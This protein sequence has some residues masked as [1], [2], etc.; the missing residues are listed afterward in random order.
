MST[1]SSPLRCCSCNQF[2][3]CKRAD[4][5]TCRKNGK[6]CTSC[7]PSEYHLCSNINPTNI[8]HPNHPSIWTN[9]YNDPSP[10]SSIP[11]PKAP[12]NPYRKTSTTP[13]KK[14]R[15]PYP[16]PQKKHPRNPFYS[17]SQPIPYRTSISTKSPLPSANPFINQQNSVPFKRTTNNI[18]TP[19]PIPPSNINS[20]PIQQHFNNQKNNN[21]KSRFNPY[22]RKGLSIDKPKIRNPYIKLTIP[23]PFEQPTN[24]PT[25][26]P[27]TKPSTNSTNTPKQSSSTTSHPTLQKQSSNS[28]SSF[29]PSD[30]DM[31]IDS[32]ISQLEN[33]E[34]STDFSVHNK[35]KKK[36]KLNQLPKQINVNRFPVNSTPSSSPSTSSSSTTSTSPTHHNSPTKQ[37][38]HPPTSIEFTPP[39]L[40]TYPIT[41]PPQHP[42]TIT[43][44]TNQQEHQID[45]ELL[46]LYGDTVHRN[47]GTHL[48]GD[49]NDDPKWYYLWFQLISYHHPL[50]TPP[51]SKLGRDI[52]KTLANE[53]QGVRDR[54]WNS[55]KALLF[56]IIILRK[57]HQKLNSQEIKQRLRFR[58]D[59]WQSG[60][61]IAL[62]TDTITE[63][64]QY[65][66][67]KSSTL[68]ID[69][70]LQIFN[71]LVYH[72]KLREAL[73]FLTSTHEEN[74]ILQ[75]NQ[76][77]PK[78]SKSVLEV[79]KSKHPPLRIP[80]ITNPE[81]ELDKFEYV[82]QPL[83]LHITE[84]DV[85]LM[86]PQLHGSGGPTSLDS[87]L[88]SDLLLRYGTSS[89]TLRTEMAAWT[90]WLANDSPPWAA[91]RATMSTRAV[92][93]NKFPGIRPISIGESYRR[94]W[95]RLVISQTRDQAKAACNTTELCAG[96]EDGIDGA[97]HA[98]RQSTINKSSFTTPIDTYHNTSSPNNTSPSSTSS[99]STPIPHSTSSTTP[100]S[101]TPQP[102]SSHSPLPSTTPQLT[103]TSPTQPPTPPT[104]ST[105]QPNIPPTKTTPTNPSPPT[106]PNL[107]PTINH[108][109]LRPRPPKQ[110]NSSSTCSASD[111]Q[112]KP[113]PPPSSSTPTPSPSPETPIPTH[114]SPTPS[115]RPQPSTSSSTTTS[116]SSN[117]VSPS[118]SSPSTNHQTSTTSETHQ[119]SPV[120][121]QYH[122]ISSTPINSSPK[123][124]SSNTPTPSPSPPHDF[125]NDPIDVTLLDASN[126]FNEI[127]RLRCLHTIRHL[128]PSASRFAFNCYRH[129][130]QICIRDHNSPATII[131]G[132]E[133][134]Q[135]GDPLSMILYG[136]AL[137]PLIDRIHTE[138][139]SIFFSENFL[140]PW[141]AD[142]A[143]IV[144]TV[145]NTITII[146]A[147]Q[148]LGPVYGYF[149]Q[150]EKSVH[151]CSKDQISKTKPQF[152]AANL[153]FQYVEGARYLGSYIGEANF[154]P[155]WIKPQIQTWVSAVQDLSIAATK[156][157][158]AAYAVFTHCLQNQ[159]SHLSRT[160][161]NLGPFLTPIEQSI[162][163]SF[164]PTLLHLEKIDDPLREVISHPI[165]L[166]GLNILNPTIQAG[167]SYDTS[168]LATESLVDCL[169]CHAEV[170]LTLHHHNI[171]ETRQQCHQKIHK[172]HDDLLSKYLENAS[173]EIQ[174]RLA[175]AKIGG[176]WLTV[177][178]KAINGTI[179]SAEEF[180]DNL[181]LRYGF[182]PDFLPKT[183][184]GCN[185]AFTV[186]HA[187]NCRKGGL[188]NLRH[189]EI[190]NE[191]AHLC[192]IALG[193]ESIINEPSI[194][195]G[196]SN[197][198]DNTSTPP[199]EHIHSHTLTAEA[200]A[201]GDKG[202]IGFWQRH[203]TTIFDA[204]IVNTDSPS[205]SSK[206]PQHI[207]DQ[208][209]SNKK[210]KYEDAC[211]QRRRDFTPL[212]YSVDGL[213]S[214]GTTL[215]EKRLAQLL[216]NKL[217]IPYSQAIFLVHS[218]MSIALIRCNSIL[219]RTS[220]DRSNNPHPR[221]PIIPDGAAI[222]SF[223]L[224]RE[225]FF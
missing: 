208:S 24:D 194:F 217:Q 94:L 178:P 127:S 173:P 35:Q 137:T 216:Q 161:P 136:L 174:H 90:E 122:P 196:K 19:N 61:Y 185:K 115:L 16:Q 224:I 38:S 17:P 166:A 85:K 121:S 138:H 4:F 53:F 111:K 140:D 193:T 93:F 89:T 203:R 118:S 171:S 158:Q 26:P 28:N 71:Q 25:T 168:L 147:I 150:P 86:A 205:Y 10:Q 40:P 220:R 190:A 124:S 169:L 82:P 218:R 163:N 133:G 212:I 70:K 99:S 101:S 51:Q 59:Q 112:T 32:V 177:I 198:P 41:N 113:Q 139:S 192:A 49:I 141:Y 180:R 81:F 23:D 184:D 67:T 151:I 7:H 8:H 209:E 211:H 201:R 126:G 132:Y 105:H 148:N 33:E 34:L 143:T 128:W 62:A 37:S 98:V 221:R 97:I 45:T 109:N 149:I 78:S 167:F 215:A 162:K 54:K 57:P 39:T 60:N 44:L 153:N 145:S 22:L 56:P 12:Q 9:H 114:H 170:D 13:S 134:I 204:Q 186:T 152:Q 108:Y 172:L 144:A 219:L 189:T 96:L 213:P 55:E 110:P 3:K 195:L 74:I 76:I 214:K 156:Y 210:I 43:D 103:S 58:L 18:K 116:T 75:P 199:F 182:T 191:W 14:I 69:E 83:P 176:S 5:C 142:D 197:N 73:Q 200:N 65:H 175:R 129:Y 36:I 202:V 2:S 159:W 222:S 130:I 187:L 157:P 77:D 29:I 80:D 46:H 1:P 119:H 47:L 21:K 183:C 223:A 64:F 6:P 92:A 42:D 165:K 120:S 11:Q 91:Y 117:T 160:T 48:T 66:D 95:A 207:L 164:L 27:S 30:N 72:G 100:P 154:F 50:Y 225:L 52:V 87:S 188:V 104:K 181:R 106:P 179:L 131:P 15:N 68:T 107:T 155:T 146:K 20:I 84:N 88:L 31:D 135:Q 102:S 206:E 79:L 125:T 123:S 63:A